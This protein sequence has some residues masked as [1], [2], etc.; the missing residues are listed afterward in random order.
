MPKPTAAKYVTI[1]DAAALLG[2]NPMTLRRWDKSG[3]LKPKRQP[4]SG[5]R[6]Y[7]MSE[8]RRL[9]AKGK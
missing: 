8:L 4:I 6:L 1:K 2:V 3:K 7:S 5:F 9:M